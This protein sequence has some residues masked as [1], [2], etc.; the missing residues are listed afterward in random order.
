[1]LW[2]P[3]AVL[4]GDEPGNAAFGGFHSISAEEGM[5]GSVAPCTSPRLGDQGLARFAS[6]DFIA[7]N[8]A[9]YRTWRI[10]NIEKF[11]WVKL[12]H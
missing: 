8:R 10:G 4:A 2:H 3:I 5:T 11:P 7:R 1:M 6:W 9:N 12:D